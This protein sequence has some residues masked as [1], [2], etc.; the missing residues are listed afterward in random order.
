MAAPPASLD[1]DPARVLAARDAVLAAPEFKVERDLQARLL[2]WLLE[3]LVNAGALLP[4]ALRLFALLVF[5]L[6][7]AVL[8]WWIARPLWQRQRQLAAAAAGLATR[9][10][11][12]AAERAR[13]LA[14]LSEGRLS[15]C[16]RSA[17]LAALALLDERGVSRGRVARTDW[18]HVA[19]GRRVQAALGEPLATLAT[20]FQRSHF[21]GRPLARADAEASL[22]ELQRLA[23]LTGTSASS[24]TPAPPGAAG[25]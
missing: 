19:A 17:W 11:D 4:Q 3:Q 13:A 22:A 12:Y 7:A 23:G 6:L 24:P 18:E 21:G 14:A 20:M 25:G 16:V 10:P 2:D 15:D 5:L 8:L 1:I 9:R